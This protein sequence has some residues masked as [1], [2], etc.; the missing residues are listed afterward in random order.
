MSSPKNN[1]LGYALKVAQLSLKNAMEDRLRALELTISQYAVL[2]QLSLNPGQTN[3]ELARHAFMSAQSMQGVLANMESTG[4]IAR[5][6]DKEHGRRQPASL[7][8]AGYEALRLATEAVQPV[9]NQLD[10]AVAPMNHADVLAVFQ[11]I[12]IKLA[13]LK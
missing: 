6:A 5:T 8:Q 1:A 4:L 7:T 13:E 12:P 11:R 2:T 3:A 9:E 10:L